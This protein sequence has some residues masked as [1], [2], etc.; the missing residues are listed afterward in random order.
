MWNNRSSLS[1]DGLQAGVFLAPDGSVAVF[2]VNLTD[3]L[4]HASFA[5]TPDRYPIDGAKPYSVVAVDEEGRERGQ[6]SEQT[7]RISFMGDIDSR[8]VLFV[9]ATPSD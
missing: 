3:E 4:V 2:V 9:R 1:L 6:T 5:L 7:G 8:D